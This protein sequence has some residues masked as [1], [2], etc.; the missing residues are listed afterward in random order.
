MQEN[1]WEALLRRI[2]AAYHDGL[3]LATVSGAEIVLQQILRIENQLLIVRG[4][5]AGSSDQGKILI[6][7]FPQINFISFKKRLSD[8]EVEG[9]F[10]ERE[11]GFAAALEVL[12]TADEKEA[13]PAEPE[14]APAASEI[15]TAPPPPA[16]PTNPT[17][18]SK[19]VLL[20]KLRARLQGDGPRGPLK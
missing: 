5:N 13:P 16:P 3:T 20:A 2:P 9:I 8:A 17:K 10:G 18:V 19:S 6:I 14:E 4:R 15:I 12:P 11:A 7:P 1:T